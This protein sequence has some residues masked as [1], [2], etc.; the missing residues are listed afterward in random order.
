MKT[1]DITVDKDGNT[2]VEAN[3][4]SGK[5]CS[6]AT[7][8]IEQAIGTIKEDRKKAEYYKPSTQKQRAF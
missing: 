1:I 4:F 8:I 3:G 7:K 6:D 5:D 2:T